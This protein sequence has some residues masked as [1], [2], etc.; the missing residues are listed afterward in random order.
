[1]SQDLFAAFGGSETSGGWNQPLASSQF[2][3]GETVA[4]S[5]TH[6]QQAPQLP[7]ASLEADLEDDFGDFEDASQVPTE[8]QGTRTSQPQAA[9]V[10]A[11]PVSQKPEKKPNG[12]ADVERHP[13]AGNMDLLFAADEDEYDAGADDRNDLSNN[14]EAA[15]AFSKQLIAA[16]EAERERERSRAKGPTATGR[17]P[18]AGNMD[19]LFAAD[20]DE[21]DAGVDDRNDLSN[22]P[23]AAMAYSKQV[24]AAQVAEQERASSRAPQVAKKMETKQKPPP[25]AVASAKGGN[26]RP[27]DPKV[28]FDADDLEP[29]EDDDDF[30]DFEGGNE[31]PPPSTKSLAQKQASDQSDMPVMNRLRLEN[32]DDVVHPHQSKHVTRKGGQPKP[33]SQQQ[34]A[35]PRRAQ[36]DLTSNMMPEDDAWDDFEVAATPST[37]SIENKAPSAPHTE[38]VQRLPARPATTT[39]TDEVPPTNVP[40]PGILL[41]VFPSI[42][43][44]AQEALFDQ[45]ARL[46]MKQRQV[47][48]AH[49][50]THQFLIGYLRTAFALGHIIAGRKLRWKRDQFLA[51]GMRIGPATAGGK[52]GGMKLAGI[53]KSEVAKEDREVLDAVRSWRAQ[54]GKLRS[55]VAAAGTTASSGTVIL[56]AVPEIAEQMPVKAL[57]PAEGG[58]TAPHACTLCGLRREERVAKVDVDVDDSF[59]EWWLQGVSMHVVCKSFWDEH[60]GKLKSR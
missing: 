52:G 13:F 20:E 5:S 41:S 8:T 54:I 26:K 16:Q 55:A 3:Q 35:A 46:D 18:F 58:I 25:S 22:N 36:H 9:V 4:S 32:G 43:T 44:A 19:L 1:M 12:S 48:T 51:Q 45:L 6:P 42:F 60:K 49:P 10:K 57:K 7:Q 37:S 34:A 28:L 21:Y 39:S 47:L 14:P 11:V 17:H 31:V 15:M 59:G 27:R 53:D 38:E 33:R 56:P 23:E 50:A 30:G 29:T 24:F 2:G 40:P